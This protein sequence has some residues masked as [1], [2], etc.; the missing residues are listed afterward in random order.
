VRLVELT[1]PADLSL[2][3]TAEI[4][5]KVAGKPIKGVSVP[6]AAMVQALIGQG[7]STEL[8]ESF[9]EMV[10]AINSGALKFQG[11]PIRGSITLEQRLRSLLA[12]VK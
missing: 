10:A 6:T 2:Q 7:A 4:L 5:S 3:D 8:A 12:P 1:G 11:T 9:G